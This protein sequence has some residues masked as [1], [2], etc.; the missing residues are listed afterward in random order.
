MEDFHHDSDALHAAKRSLLVREWIPAPNASLR[1]MFF[2]VLR[3]QEMPGSNSERPVL[4]DVF[5]KRPQ[6]RGN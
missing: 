1:M 2:L 6:H 4:A 5:E 3:A